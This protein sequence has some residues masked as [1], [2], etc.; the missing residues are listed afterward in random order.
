M[1]KYLIGTNTMILEFKACGTLY[2]K[3]KMTTTLL[4]N[5]EYKLK[6]WDDRTSGLNKTKPK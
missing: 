1:I 3:L 4:T 6:Q 2:R 5:E